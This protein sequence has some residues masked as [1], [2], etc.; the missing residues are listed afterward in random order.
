MEKSSGMILATRAFVIAVACPLATHAATMSL[1]MMGAEATVQ[2]P[3]GSQKMDFTAYIIDT[4]VDTGGVGVRGGGGTPPV[5]PQPNKAQATAQVN[6]AAAQRK[7]QQ[8]EKAVADAKR[9]ATRLATAK[10]ADAKAKQ[11]AENQVKKAEEKLKQ[12]TASLQQAEA[13]PNLVNIGVS[14]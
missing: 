12:A 8:Q 14:N 5:A 11:E 4:G 10:N 2:V 1:P 3:S 9:D 13:D 7:K 6:K